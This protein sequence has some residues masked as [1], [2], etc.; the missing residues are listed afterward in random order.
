MLINRET[1]M[2]CGTVSFDSMAT[3]EGNRKFA[4]EQR[5]KMT[6]RMGTEFVDVLECELAVHHLRVPELV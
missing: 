2:M 4:T 1:G 3:V 6:E 5:T